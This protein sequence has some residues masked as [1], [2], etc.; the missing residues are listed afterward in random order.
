MKTSRSK[1]GAKAAGLTKNQKRK[2]AYAAK[3]KTEQ[4]ERRQGKL[5]KHIQRKSARAA[6]LVGSAKHFVPCGNHACQSCP[7]RRGG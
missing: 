2:A 7:R 5:G 6:R 1:L 4:T 3:A